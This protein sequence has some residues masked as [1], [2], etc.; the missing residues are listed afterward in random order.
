MAESD[1]ALAV[2]CQHDEDA[3]RELFHRYHRRLYQ[4]ARGMLGSAEDAEEVTQDTFVRLFKFAHHF[5]SRRKFATWVYTI[6]ANQCRNRLRH[7]RDHSAQSLD[8]EDVPELADPSAEGP[9]EVY[10][11][12]T[13][14]EMVDDAIEELPPVYR[15][16]L[17]LRYLEG[18]SYKEIA[19]TLQVSLS[20]VETRIFRAKGHLR[21]QLAAMTSTTTEARPS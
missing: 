1:E 9:L 5:D 20:A 19:Q 7:R 21:G 18:M 15:E 4:Y 16:V 11:N 3:F 6:A 8:A 13:V 2:R 10:E 14:R 17:H 12:A